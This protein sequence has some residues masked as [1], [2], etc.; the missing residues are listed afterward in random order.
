MAL[1]LVP[2]QIFFDSLIFFDYI[3][4]CVVLREVFKSNPELLNQK[5]GN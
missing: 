2:A 3:F 1:S 5:K 4:K